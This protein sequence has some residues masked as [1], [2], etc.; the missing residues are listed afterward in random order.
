MAS[1][2]RSCLELLGGIYFIG[3]L[4]KINSTST[5][6]VTSETEHEGSQADT[7]EQWDKRPADNGFCAIT[8]SN[9]QALEGGN[10]A[11]FDFVQL[12]EPIKDALM[13]VL[14]QK[15]SFP[16]VRITNRRMGKICT[17]LCIA[18]SSQGT[19]CGPA[20]NSISLEDI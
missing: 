3:E 5:S 1:T 16:A 14:D 2:V 10:L 4:Q 8:P 19:S 11:E 6:N 15:G 7:K 17:D 20:S 12:M 13:K 18:D 9:P